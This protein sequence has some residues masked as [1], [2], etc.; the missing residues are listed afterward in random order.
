MKRTRLAAVIALILVAATPIAGHA[1]S[2]TS[3]FTD[4]FDGTDGTTL[5]NGWQEAQGDLLLD[6]GELRNAVGT[7]DPS[8]AVQLS[9]FSDAQ[10]ASAMFASTNNNSVPVLGFVLRYESP[11]RYY[12]LY[13]LG[14]ATSVLRIAKVTNGQEVILGQAGVPNPA[15]N[16]VFTLSATARSNTLTL[17]LE[18]VKTV[19]V[20]DS[21]IPIPSGYVGVLLGTKTTNAALRVSH[22]ADNFQATFTTSGAPA[23]H[24]AASLSSD[25]APRTVE[26]GTPAISFA[27]VILDAGGSAEDVSVSS[28]QL[29]LETDIGSTDPEACQL[30][31]GASPLTTGSNVVD[32]TVDGIYTFTLDNRAVVPM[33]TQRTLTLRCNIPASAASGDTIE[34][35]VTSADVIGAQGATTGQDVVVQIHDSPDDQNRVTVQPGGAGPGTIDPAQLQ[36]VLRA[37]EISLGPDLGEE[38]PPLAAHTAVNFEGPSPPSS[39]WLSVYNQKTYGDLTVSADMLDSEIN[40]EQC[41]GVAALVP[42]GSSGRAIVAR[43]CDAKNTD[44]LRLGILDTATGAVTSL[45]NSNLFSRIDTYGGTNPPADCDHHQHQADYHMYCQ[46][47]RTS[48]TITTNPNGTVTFTASTWLRGTGLK[49]DPSRNNPTS[50]ALTLIGTATWTGLRPVNVATTG[51]V[52]LVGTATQGWERL[53]LTNLDVDP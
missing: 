34:W 22:R 45:V 4:A 46:W 36:S 30:L 53:S 28:V 29:D 50:P 13:R 42:A 32:P 52:G 43:S 41:G 19:T 10:S 38:A 27:N 35:R 49:N 2:T 47:V 24:L 14:G 9:S 11:Q 37:S 33:Q 8:I 44:T 39:A 40:G 16:A 3:T 20:T 15:A 31:D 7:G 26:P 5:G 6:N 17:T 51:K 1:A 25:P 12:A 21:G 23:P 48:L 18:G